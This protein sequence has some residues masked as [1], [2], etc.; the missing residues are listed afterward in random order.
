MTTETP[1]TPTRRAAL[2]LLDAVLRRGLPLEAAMDGACGDLDRGDDRAFAH[3][4]AAEVLRRTTDLDAL[5]DTPPNGR[6]RPTPRR[7]WCCAWR[8]SRRWR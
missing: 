4:I 5:I 2:R 7:G 6:C 3:A 8:W 1:G